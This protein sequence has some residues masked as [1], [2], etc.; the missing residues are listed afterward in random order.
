MDAGN[1]KGTDLARFLALEF[2]R[3]MEGLGLERTALA[4]MRVIKIQEK[5]VP[6]YFLAP[7]IKKHCG[8]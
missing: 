1:P 3:S 6:L 7:F 8:L 2:A 4:D 5:N